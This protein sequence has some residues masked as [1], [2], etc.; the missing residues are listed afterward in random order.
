ME[1]VPLQNLPR[2]QLKVNL[3]G[4]T[5]T[6]TFVAIENIMYAT[7]AINDVVISNGARCVKGYPIVPY[8]ALEGKTGNFIFLT[9]GEDVPWWEN[10][11]INQTLYYLTANEL[12]Y[13]RQVL[14]SA[15]IY[16][17]AYRQK[18]YQ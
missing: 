12:A 6:L 8:P 13:T 7:V 2:Q 14:S 4:V 18:Y 15:L 16:M 3:D 11:G 1:I 9:N 10:F 17:L 5:Y